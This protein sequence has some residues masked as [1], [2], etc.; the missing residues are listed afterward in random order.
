MNTKPSAHER[1]SGDVP[2]STDRPLITVVYPLFDIRG[3]AVDALRTWAE[4][5]TLSRALYRVHVMFSEECGPVPHALLAVLADGDRLIH[6]PDGNDAAM[7]NAG[8]AQA[9]TS[10][11]VLVEGHSMADP[12]CL[13]HTAAW[14]SA[15]CG[16][17]GNFAV[18]HNDDHLMARLAERWFAQIQSIWR[19]AEGWPHVHRTGFAIQADVFSRAGGFASEYGQFAPALLS[20]RLH[21]SGVQIG[22]ISGAAVLHLDDAMVADHHY[23]TADYAAGEIACRSREEQVFFER[24]F[25]HSD[26]WSNRLCRAPFM[27]RLMVRAL[28]ASS[29][30]HPRHLLA[31]GSIAAGLVLNS[32]Q[33]TSAGRLLQH[34]LIKF[35]EFAIVHLPLPTS[36]R[37]RW[38]LNAHKRV[39]AQTQRD[40]RVKTVLSPRRKAPVSLSIDLATPCDLSGVHALD[41]FEGKNFRWTWPVFVLGSSRS[42]SVVIHIDTVGCVAIHST[43][44]SPS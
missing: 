34:A 44:L 37:W 2:E 22:C 27:R 40:W 10:W 17:I 5:Q 12:R 19:S 38:F 15:G 3:S 4:T 6:V 16:V 20:A 11:L 43:A 21:A 1:I 14:I 13:E 42:H 23:D 18:F 26:L 41:R 36:L 29:L 7:W 9:T 39:V 35:L 25:G 24:Y 33:E 31:L 30:S 32:L 28:V 8:A